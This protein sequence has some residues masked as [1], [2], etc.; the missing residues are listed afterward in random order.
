MVKIL[1]VTIA[2]AGGDKRSIGEIGRVVRIY[3]HELERSLESSRVHEPDRDAAAQDKLPQGICT[4]AA[5]R[6]HVK[7]LRQN[8]HRC[9]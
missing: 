2:S 9:H 3:L 8:R 4:A 1:Q 7:G 5:W 6:E